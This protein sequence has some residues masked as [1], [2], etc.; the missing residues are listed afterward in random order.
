MDDPTSLEKSTNTHTESKDP[1]EIFLLTIVAVMFVI[2]LV[3]VLDNFFHF[4]PALS[5]EE[6]T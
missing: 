3:L 4:L 1:P 2:V 5:P 6:L